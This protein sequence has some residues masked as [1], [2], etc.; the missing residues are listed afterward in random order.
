MKLFVDVTDAVGLSFVHT[1]GAPASYEIP[2]AIGS[3]C[4]WIDA[5][6][7]QRLDLRPDRQA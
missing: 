1:D 4:G 7:D 5:N 2:R 6:G 3:G